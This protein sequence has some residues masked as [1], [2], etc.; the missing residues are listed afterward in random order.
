MWGRPPETCSELRFVVDSMLGS[1]VRWLRML[2]YEAEYNSKADDNNL[3]RRSLETDS[4]LLTRDEELY[5]RARAKRLNTILVLGEDDETRLGQLA[6]SLGLSMEL[7]M[8]KARCP[9]C[10]ST[11]REISLSEASAT[12]PEGSLK[13]YN[14]F[15]KCTNMECSKTYWM[16]SHLRNI[17]HS[18]EEA[19]RMARSGESQC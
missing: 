4:T 8:A 3:L 10:G 18:L 14:K 7:N 13:A 2:G 15:W 5:N 17:Q 1:L 11:L 19:R 16:G 12:V 9:E 6:T